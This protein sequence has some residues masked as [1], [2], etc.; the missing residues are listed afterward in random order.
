MGIHLLIQPLIICLLRIIDVSLGTVRIIIMF[1][2]KKL[3]ATIIG[4]VEVFIYISV[5]SY[6]LSNI[7]NLWNMLGYSIGFASGVYIG[8]LLEEKL[9]L[10]LMT[11][12]IIPTKDADLL[13]NIIRDNGFGVTAMEGWGRDGAKTILTIHLYRRDWKNN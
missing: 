2:G 13:S 11:V 10:G 8:S 1:K 5:L 7:D 6:V 9:A 4:F 12:Q 3:L